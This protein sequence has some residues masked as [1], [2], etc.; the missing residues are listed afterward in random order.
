MGD[1]GGSAA[2][3][4]LGVSKWQRD[5]WIAQIEHAQSGQPR[6]PDLS[7]LPGFS[8][9]AVIRHAVTTP[10]L[11]HG[12]DKCNAGKPYHRQVR[13]FGFMVVFQQKDDLVTS[14]KKPSTLRVIAPFDRD[15]A[16][17]ARHAFDRD[18]G[19]PVSPKQLKSYADALRHYYNQPEAK[20]LNGERG[21]RGP[22][23]RR[24]ITARTIRFIGKEANRLD[25]QLA[26]GVDPSAQAEF[27]SVSE[28][29]AKRVAEIRD[30]I[31]KYGPLLVSRRADISRQYL[32]RILN[33]ENV[34]TEAIFSKIEHA[35]SNLALA[36]GNR[37]V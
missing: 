6:P 25:D 1:K 2:Q 16:K 32:F 20:F 15:P 34:A 8:K 3:L 9:P 5:F 31:K 29:R 26:I 4:P 11:C 27:G 28:E 12:Y 35:I 30:A 7:R 13:P 36:D 21:D 23:L 17:A 14:G 19:A 18:T 22:T 33:D 10:D 37:Q 24:H